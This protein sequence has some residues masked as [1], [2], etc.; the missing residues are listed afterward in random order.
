[1]IDDKLYMRISDRQIRAETSLQDEKGWCVLRDAVCKV[2]ITCSGSEALVRYS[3]LLL[4]L[5]I[6]LSK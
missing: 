2:Y 6:A 1:M 4:S 5:P 3:P